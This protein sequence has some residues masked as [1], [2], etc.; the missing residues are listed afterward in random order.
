M[1][2][3]PGLVIA[4]MIAGGCADGS[5][6]PTLDPT[7]QEPTSTLGAEAPAAAS[8]IVVDEAPTFDAEETATFVGRADIN[9]TGNR[10]SVGA[11][12]LDGPSID[13]QLESAAMWIV[14]TSNEAGAPWIAALADGTLVSIDLF[15][16]AVVVLDPAW[17]DAEPAVVSGTIRRV[18]PVWDGA[19]PLPDARLVRDDTMSVMLTDPTDRYAHDVLGDDLEA[20]AIEVIGD[21]A[22]RIELDGDVVEGRSALLGDVDGDATNEI[23]VTQSNAVVGARL[24]LY[25]SD[26]GQIAAS[27]PI[28]RG[29]RWRNQLA[30]A[31]VGPNGEVEI[32]D[33]RTPHLGRTIEWFRIEGDQL[34]RVAAR[35]GFTSH[36]LGSRNLDLAIVADADSDGL[37]EVVAPTSDRRGLSAIARTVDGTTIEFT[38]ELDAPLSSN[39]GAVDHPDG[40]ATYAVGT[41]SGM[42]RFWVS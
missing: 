38:V 33:V 39:V 8:S 11:G 4:A 18:E 15:S 29:N 1:R 31:P 32:I 26:G 30:I 35:D 22:T 28:G 19:A 3:L 42:V 7:V 23:L 36:V 41:S 9:L 27:E 10:V 12:D 6:R 21:V 24:V 40:G 20:A 2:L 17:G 34:V 13:L 14:P 5:Q 37:L 16:S 25:G